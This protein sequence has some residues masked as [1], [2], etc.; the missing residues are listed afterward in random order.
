MRLWD[1]PVPIS[2]TMVK[3]QTAD[4]TLLE[5]ARESRW[6]PA[7]KKI[8]SSQRREVAGSNSVKADRKKGKSD[9]SFV[10][11]RNVP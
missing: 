6:M 10:P 4:G 9:F 1:T 11:E 3:T 8:K 2:N 7:Y 5:T